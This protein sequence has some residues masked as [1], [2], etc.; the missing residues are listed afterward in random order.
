[1]PG[2]W[3]ERNKACE[4]DGKAPGQ[5]CERMGRLL[6]GRKPQREEERG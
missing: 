2:A 3:V 4:E 6:V 1:M 5:A